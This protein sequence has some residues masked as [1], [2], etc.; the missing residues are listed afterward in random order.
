MPWQA[1]VPGPASASLFIL[2]QGRVETRGEET[3]LPYSTTTSMSCWMCA[4]QIVFGTTTYIA[5]T[6]PD[7]CILCSTRAGVAV[8]IFPLAL[9]P[10]WKNSVVCSLHI[11]DQGDLPPKL[12]SLC[13]KHFIPVLVRAGL[14]PESACASAWGQLARDCWCSHTCS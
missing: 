9:L 4:H 14:D 8:S 2:N 11:P 3:L 6:K 5:A 7:Y 10:K 1:V 12:C 13:L